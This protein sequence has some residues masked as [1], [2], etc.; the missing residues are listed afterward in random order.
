[1]S[2]PT[3]KAFLVPGLQVGRQCRGHLGNEALGGDWHR[4]PGQG[5]VV[6]LPPREVV[7]KSPRLFKVPAKQCPPISWYRRWRRTPRP[8]GPPGPAL[9]AH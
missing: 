1:M 6:G 8:L 4:V 2:S 9:P 3:L 5:L 7:E